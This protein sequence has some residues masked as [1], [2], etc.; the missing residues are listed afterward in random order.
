MSLESKIV[1]LI[2]ALEANTAAIQA[3]V[4]NAPAASPA[5]PQATP[6]AVAPVPNAV[7]SPVT[8]AAAPATPPV[9][10]APAAVSP[11][12]VAITLEQLQQEITSIYQAKSGDPR[13]MALVQQYGA[14]LTEVPAEQYA[15]LIAAARAL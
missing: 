10:V 9:A 13:V 4:G 5:I 2:T 3:N 1:L 12:E 11:S 7:P 6:A 14:S 8:P 15:N